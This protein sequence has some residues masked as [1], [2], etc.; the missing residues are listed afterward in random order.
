MTLRHRM[1]RQGDQQ[2]IVAL[3]RE[4]AVEQKS[5]ARFCQNAGKIAGDILRRGSS[6]NCILLFDGDEAIGI[7]VWFWSYRSFSGQ[8]GLFLEDLYV[9]ATHRRQGGGK[10]LMGALA[11]TAATRNAF[12]EWLVFDWNQP[13]MRFYE[14]LGAKAK[15]GFIACELRGAGLAGLVT[16]TGHGAAAMASP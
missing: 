4:A 10:L 8:H 13:A 7:A 12:M 11:R 6:A 15:D 14:G 2:A 1:A 9:R 5:G 16:G 3:L